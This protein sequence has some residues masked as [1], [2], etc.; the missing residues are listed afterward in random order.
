MAVKCWLSVGI[1]GNTLLYLTLS[2]SYNPHFPS[3]CTI[4][5]EMGILR[6]RSTYKA[7]AEAYLGHAYSLYVGRP[8]KNARSE[9]VAI[10]YEIVY[11]Q[12]RMR[13]CQCESSERKVGKKYSPRERSQAHFAPCESKF[14]V[15][16]EGMSNN[17]LWSPLAHGLT[18][19]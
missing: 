8:R 9:A 18:G 1:A 3:Q 7:R 14:L 5:C 12:L 11:Y 10:F 16:G 6:G 17:R 2:Y 4:T 19:Q 13:G 15:S